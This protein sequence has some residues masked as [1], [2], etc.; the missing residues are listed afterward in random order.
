MAISPFI[1]RNT[2]I[3]HQVVE[4]W[5]YPHYPE[6]NDVVL[7]T[8]P[9]RIQSQITQI[10]QQISNPNSSYNQQL[11]PGYLLVEVGGHGNTLT[12]ALDGARLFAESVSQVLSGMKG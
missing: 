7:S 2:A 9:A 3:N 8:S 12:E 11:S 6:K 5:D 10:G 1:P 4:Y